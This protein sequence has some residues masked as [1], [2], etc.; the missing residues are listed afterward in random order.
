MIEEKSP[1]G[2]LCIWIKIPCAFAFADRIPCPHG[3]P[4]AT[5]H[6]ANLHLDAT[7]MAVYINPVVVADFEIGGEIAMQEQPVE[8]VDLSQPCVLRPP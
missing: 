6:G 3:V 4:V 8:S 2:F 7:V 5:G 1:S